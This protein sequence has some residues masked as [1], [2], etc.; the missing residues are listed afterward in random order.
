MLTHSK[1]QDVARVAQ[2]RDE[3]LQC[4]AALMTANSELLRAQVCYQQKKL[5]AGAFYMFKEGGKTQVCAHHLVVHAS[6]LQ[7]RRDCSIRYPTTSL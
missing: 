7:S 4:A 6:A 1:S 5:P 2:Q 3:V